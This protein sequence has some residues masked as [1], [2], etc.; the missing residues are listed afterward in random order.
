MRLCVSGAQRWAPGAQIWAASSGTWEL[1]E[2]WTPSPQWQSPAS[3]GGSSVCFQNRFW[4]AQN[5]KNPPQIVKAAS[6]GCMLRD[7]PSP[8]ILQPRGQGQQ[9]VAQGTT[10]PHGILRMRASQAWS[11]ASPCS[12]SWLLAGPGGCWES[13]LSANPKILTIQPRI[14]P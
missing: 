14:R 6:H 2:A 13:G 11:G 10:R 7:F 4:A 5:G 1:G 8:F 3:A 9:T 12:A